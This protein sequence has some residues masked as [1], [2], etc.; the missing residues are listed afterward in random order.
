MPEP[1]SALGKTDKDVRHSIRDVISAFRQRQY[2][3]ALRL[4]LWSLIPV[5]TAIG[6]VLVIVTY[7]QD[8]DS[9]SLAPAPTQLP[10]T[11]IAPVMPVPD[12]HRDQS[13][14][15]PP[16]FTASKLEADVSKKMDAVAAEAGHEYERASYEVQVPNN[17]VTI[18]TAPATCQGFT[19][20]TQGDLDYE[21]RRSLP[22]STAGINAIV[23]VTAGYKWMTGQG[24]GRSVIAYGRFAICA[25]YSPAPCTAP[26]ISCDTAPLCSFESRSGE[27]NRGRAL[28]ALSSV[29]AS[30]L[31]A[32]QM[33]AQ[34]P[35]GE[36]QCLD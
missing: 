11:R 23:R 28:E 21:V 15:L 10:E 17:G 36:M 5:A 7:C 26:E 14:A 2:F 32:S 9:R 19:A 31:K 18:E 20:F 3:R 27:G 35:I 29:I 30:R 22:E 25:P 24:S 13:V 12:G 8:H 34:Q 33:D 1:S 6:S 16:S 4:L